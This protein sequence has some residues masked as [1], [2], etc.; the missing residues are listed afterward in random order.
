MNITVTLQV[1]GT[2]ENRLMDILVG[3]P[4]ILWI[5]GH[6]HFLLLV[7]RG[8]GMLG[9]ILISEPLTVTLGL[10]QIRSTRIPVNMVADLMDGN[11]T[12]NSRR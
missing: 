4:P 5:R 9:R 11:V 12:F 3:S 10:A 2:V 1:I 6:I 7:T 8:A